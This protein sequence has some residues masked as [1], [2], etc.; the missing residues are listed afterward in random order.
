MLSENNVKILKFYLHISKE[1]QKKRLLDRLSNPE[2]RWK[3]NE[4]DYEKRKKWDKYMS[5]YSDAINVCSLKQAPWYVIPANK[6]WFR[7]WVISEI[8]TKTMIEM[9]IKYPQLPS[10]DNIKI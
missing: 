4:E 3:V 9:K 5:A 10:Q 7:N 6:K 8:I 2:K 1:E